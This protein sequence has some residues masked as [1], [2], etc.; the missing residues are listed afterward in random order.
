MLWMPPA[1][2]GG[3][4]SGASF[5]RLGEARF[6]ATDSVGGAWR[7]DE[8]HVGPALGL[9]T[10]LV[11]RDRDAT[12]RRRPGAEPAVLRRPRHDARRTSSRPRVEVLRAGRT[13]ELVEAV[14]AARG[15]SDAQCACARGCCSR[16]TPTRWPGSAHPRL[17]P[18]EDLPPWDPTTVWPGGF[19]AAAEVRRGQEG[20]G[21][22]RA[23]GCG[24]G[25]PLVEGEPT[26]RVPRLRRAWSTSPT[27]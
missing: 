23:T 15:A 7:S 21:T 22:R 6:R 17:P 4:V 18:P 3:G 13:I 16:A 20:A 1:E 14:L 27:A 25:V 19:I 26:S 10:H 11:E 2:V 5:E 8:Q 24:R 9:L 12:P